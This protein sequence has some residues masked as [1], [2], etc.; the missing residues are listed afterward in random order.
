MRP[1]RLELENFGVYRGKHILDLSPLSFFVIR[2]RTG[3]GKSTLMDAICYALYG[4]A[5]R[6]GEQKVHKHLISRGSKRMH[7]ALDFSV[8]GKLYRIEREYDGNKSDF[9]FYE[10][11]TPRSLREKELEERIKE[12]LRLDYSTFTKVLL[13]PQNQFD[14]FLKPA[15]KGDRREILNSLLGFAELFSHLKKLLG[16]EYKEKMGRLEALQTRLS[17]LKDLSPE[18][19]A[20][21]QQDMHRLQEEYE[22]LLEGRSKTQELLEVCKERD[23]LIREASALKS[24]FDEL[25]SRREDMERV[26]NKLEV[27]IRLLPYLKRLEEY[28]RIIKQEEEYT[29]DKRR[30][31]LELKRCS[32]ERMRREEELKM[33]EEEVG[34]IE[35][36]NKKSIQLSNALQLLRSYSDLN[37]EIKA[38]MEQLNG[39]RDKIEVEAKAEMECR[40]RIEKGLKHTKE[41][42]ERIE[43]YERSDV[44][45]RIKLVEKLKEQLSR[46]RLIRADREKESSQLKDVDKKLQEHKE[47]LRQEEEK[48]KKLDKD[49]QELE[50]LIQKLRSSV[51][52]EGVLRELYSKFREL[53]DIEKQSA[54]L[55]KEAIAFRDELVRVE[56][57]ISALEGR[58]LE[59]YAL[60]IRSGLSPGSKCPVCGGVV[61][62]EEHIEVR[63]D[64]RALIS[65]LE[66]LRKRRESIG[67]SL[68]WKEAQLSMLKE[69][70]QRLADG[71][72]S[73]TIR[74]DE[75]EERLKTIEKD[76][77]ILTERERELATLKENHRK[78]AHELEEL[79]AEESGLKMRL[80][81]L[82]SLIQR[83]EEEERA[84]FE[85][86]GAKPVEEI[87]REIQEVERDH[88][89][90]KSLR[91]K[92]KKYV[93]K[94]E[95]L[96]GELSQKEKELE[97]LKEREKSLVEQVDA[98]SLKLK[99]LEEEVK[100][101]TGER[102][103]DYLE[104]RLTNELQSLSRRIK[105]AQER[106]TETSKH[107]QEVKAR[108]ANLL[109]DL[110]NI[111]GFLKKLQEQKSAIAEDLYELDRGFGSLEEAKKHILSEEEIK[112]LRQ[113]LESYEKEK[114]NVEKRLQEIESKLSS[115][116]DLPQ[117]EE[118]E[119]TFRE[120]EER[121]HAN[122]E[123]YGKIKNELERLKEDLKEKE[124]LIKN[125]E[126]LK[127]EIGLY[128]RLKSDLADNQFPEFVS[129]IMLQKLIDRGNY[130][131]FKFTSGQFNFELVEGDLQVFDHST[132][133]HRPV[134]SLSGGETF[135]ASLS[136]AFAVADILSQ[137][138]PLESLFIDEGFGSLDKETRESL[139]EF[140]DLIRE[141]ADRM[142]GIITHVE[143]VADKFS[144]RI[145]IEKKDGS[146][147]IKVIY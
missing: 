15:G 101:K 27:A 75:I 97:K 119:R 3:A 102:P 103:S 28:E 121:V 34:R 145:E 39:L 98:M 47:K 81:S 110:K 52:E 105:E 92:E 63:E 25:I 143:D 133:H 79:K 26:R 84:L 60:E 9:R 114:H 43:A 56:K 46:L 29:K 126:E 54:E 31:E 40:Q 44:E 14:R 95:E 51:E 85:S 50:G 41:V 13:L 115:F 117:T 45:E 108:E 21:L 1:V 77:S 70:R 65:R 100:R 6:Y 99:E 120:L 96:Q 136:L 94:L 88:Q 18:V 5:P 61:L 2:G 83:L 64:I 4:K 67:M 80:S 33:A 24:S 59:I 57:E 32:E 37:K 36:Y 141:S 111:E 16:E 30:K 130:Y 74:M 144:Q 78:L 118:V 11:G 138:A 123:L 42:R 147:V 82:N 106:Y 68:S 53:E 89:E 48:H 66:E 142:V 140:F 58:R 128:E 19:I 132:G 113:V 124:G 90:L 109:S 127:R 135:L 7:V 87:E 55:E 137:N 35:E 116:Q 76:K 38:L 122:R 93:Q 23:S 112:D 72:E 131:L 12:L 104:R 62:G 139:S 73:A 69:K 71:L 129:L 20:Q 86:F 10:G 17:Q 134:S 91:E 49:I 8:R 125:I 146:A 22:S 107:L